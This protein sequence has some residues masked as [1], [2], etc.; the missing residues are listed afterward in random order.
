MSWIEE[1][2]RSESMLLQ[3]LFHIGALGANSFKIL[4]GI[5]SGPMALA[6]FMPD[7]ECWTSLTVT[8]R[9]R[10]TCWMIGSLT[11]I[12]SK[13]AVKLIKWSFTLLASDF[14]SGHLS[15]INWWN[16]S[17]CMFGPSVTLFLSTTFSYH[18]SRDRLPCDVEFCFLGSYTMHNKVKANE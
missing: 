3:E 9:S 11:G 12:R 17:C 2:Y 13:S 4:F 16:N 8:S 18:C 15:S 1:K 14:V 10:G 7:S 6:T 5:M